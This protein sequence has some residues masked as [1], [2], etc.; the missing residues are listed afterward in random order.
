MQLTSGQKL[1]CERVVNVFETGSIN[2]DYS[3]ISIY[4]DSPSKT[5]QITYGR[6]QTTEYGNLKELVS[7]Y[8]AA[9]GK[10][11]A[12]LAPYVPKIG[13][14]PL[15]QNAAFKDLLRKAGR[16]DPVMAATQDAFFDKRYW[17]PAVK[18]CEDH[19][20]T[21][22]LSMLVVYDSFIHSG[23]ILDFL[24][25]RFAEKPPSDGGSEETWI[26]QYV[27]TRHAW[28]SGHISG[29]LRQTIYRT[30]CFKRELGRENWDL[31]LSPIIANGVRVYPAPDASQE[32]KE[33]PAAP[34]LDQPP[35]GEPEAESPPADAPIWLAVMISRLGIKEVPGG[36]SNPVIDRWF[37][38]LGH[39][40]SKDDTSWCA[41]CVGATLLECKLPVPPT[42]VNLLA[43]SYLT[44]GVACE[45]KPGAIAIWPRGDSA[46]QGHVNIVEKVLADGR[47]VC[48]GG[49]QSD[50][51]TRAAPRDPGEALG[52]RWPVAATVKA[53]RDAGSTEIKAADTTATAA[54]TILGGSAATAAISEAFK[55]PAAAPDIP[56][57]E[58]AE[59]VGL[60]KTIA[61]GLHG[62]LSVLAAHPGVIVAAVVGIA[63]F[64]LAQRWK[65]NRL[66]KA[67]AGVPLSSA[68]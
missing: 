27:D 19:G 46:W 49:N 52:F 34:V 21:K 62:L 57:K 8:A 30:A 40:G 53:L 28:L 9:G 65:A 11:S 35:A 63:L 32:P 44:Y 47:V 36:G 38:A 29:V 51:V 7:M 54:K 1:L 13:K 10:Y 68:V 39:A 45:P 18:W 50:A 56:L 17:Q 3:Q 58:V 15:D 66:A 2:G 4:S 12:S 37:S 43:R 61:E 24:R 16:E 22:A 5:R 48:I 31:A 14:T 20:F 6:S 26:K 42:N 60:S 33:A 64:F 59:Q 23:G 41:C 67:A 55:A 25:E